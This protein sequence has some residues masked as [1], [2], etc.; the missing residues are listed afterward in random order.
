MRYL[1]QSYYIACGGPKQDTDNVIS[2]FHFFVGK[3]YYHR[4]FTSSSLSISFAFTTL[5]WI[6][7][8]QYHNMRVSIPVLNGKTLVFKIIH[9]PTAAEQPYES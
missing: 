4:L 2:V 5:H 6:Q 1:R 3:S 7:V 9:C 8:C